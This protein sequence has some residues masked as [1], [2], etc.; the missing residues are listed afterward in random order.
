M[1]PGTQVTFLLR[2]FL[3]LLISLYHYYYYQ[4]MAKDVIGTPIFLQKQRLTVRTYLAPNIM[5]SSAIFGVLATWM[6]FI[7]AFLP[8]TALHA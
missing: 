6:A 7:L 8:L 1:A 5:Y 4:D 3:Q 2:L